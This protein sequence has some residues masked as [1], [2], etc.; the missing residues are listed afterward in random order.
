MAWPTPA[1]VVNA[2]GQELGLISWTAPIA[3]PFASTDKNV[4]QM[5]AL[6]LKLGQDL[7]RQHPW[8]QL[9]VEGSITTV[10]GVASYP[11]PTGF[12]RF[13]DGTAWNRTTQLP[14]PS[15]GPQGWQQVQARTSGGLVNKLMRVYG[16]AIH[17]YE[18]PTAAETIYYEYQTGLWLRDTIPAWANNTAYTE[19]QLRVASGGYVIECVGS[20]TSAVAPSTGPSCPFAG[21]DSTDGTVDWE[22]PYPSVDAAPPTAASSDTST[23]YLYFDFRLLVDGLKLSFRRHKGLDTTAEQQAYDAT[24]S[25]VLGGDGVAPV[26][27]LNSGGGSALIGPGNAPE[28]GYG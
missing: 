16:G 25:A 19:G 3:Y 15:T 14:M 23:D 6:L 9:Q 22:N 28:G 10:S 24:L 4:Q 5:N 8:S 13:V 27:S 21:V 17:L 12:L 2:A 1:Q 20:G 18:T 11:L 7:A 26:L